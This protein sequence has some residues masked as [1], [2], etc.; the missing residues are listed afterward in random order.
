MPVE[1]VL[2]ALGSSRHGLAE[3]LGPGA[4]A[5]AVGPSAVVF[6]AVEVEKWIGRRRGAART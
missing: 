2:T 5:L 4:L 6:A 1:H 3:P